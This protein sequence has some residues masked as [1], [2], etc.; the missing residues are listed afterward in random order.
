MFRKEKAA[1]L[2]LEDGT[3]FEGYSVGA[4]VSS[5]G[6]VV[7]STGLVGYPQSLTDPSYCGQILAFTYPLI[8]NYGVP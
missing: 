7:F 5:E 4:D 8:G 6:E 3:V 2:V 1:M